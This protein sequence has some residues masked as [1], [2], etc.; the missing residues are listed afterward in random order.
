MASQGSEL[1]GNIGC[2]FNELCSL[3]DQSMASTSEWIMDR[4][5]QGKYFATLLGGK[6]CCDQRAATS[7]GF[8]HQRAE[9]RGR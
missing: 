3:P 5:G 8:D 2:C 4:A 9:T 6:A 1:G 7:C